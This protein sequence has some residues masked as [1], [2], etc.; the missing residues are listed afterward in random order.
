MFFSDMVN[1]GT[2]PAMEKMLAY[3]QARHRMLTENV[4]N[5]DTPG[6]AAKQLD[7]KEFQH[8]LRAAIDTGK[9]DGTSELQIKGTRQFRQDQQGHLMITPTT[10]PAENLLFHD[11]TNMR[12]EEQMAMLAEN[13]MMHQ[14]VTE[15]LR[16]KFESM[17]KAI[18]GTAR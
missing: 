6:Y 2:L 12:I 1:S 9:K 13:A 7:T 5:A 18:R 15:L 10:E 14:T 4:A 3:T 17:L 8:A 11:H 16:G